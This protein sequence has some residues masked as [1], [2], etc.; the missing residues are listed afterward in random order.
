MKTALASEMREMDRTAIEEYGIPG[1]VLME[2][3]SRTVFE[4]IM[5]IAAEKGFSSAA[6]VCGIG[7]NGGDGFAVAR[8]LDHAG[9]ET[10]V[11]TV[12]DTEKIKGD[13]LINYSAAKKLGIS[14]TGSFN[15]YFLEKCHIIIDAIF[16]TGF[17]VAPKPPFDSVIEKINSLNKYVVSIDVPSG[18]NSDT[19]NVEGACVNADETV[20]FVMP[21]TGMLLYPAAKH[22][23]KITVSDIGMPK[24]ITEGFSS[25][26]L[27]LS[28]NEAKAMLPKRVPDGNKGTFGRVYVAAG[29]ESMMGA[30]YFSSSAA[31]KTGCGLVYCCIPEKCTSLM[32]AL[33][34]EAVEKPLR[35]LSGQFYSESFKRIENEIKL[36]KTVIVGPGIGKGSEIADF[37]HT[38]ILKCTQPL[39]ID[40]DAINA[41][42]HNLTVLKEIKHMSV[43]TPHMGEM[44]RLT[45]I[46]IEEIKKDMIKCAKDF[47][48][49]YNI[50][51]VLKDARTVVASPEGR[52]YINTTGNNSMATGGSGDV[53]T[54]IIGGLLA[55]G[56]SAFEAAVLGTYIHGKCGD[57]AAEEKGHYSVL[58]GDLLAFL[59][60]A[61]KNME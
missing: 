58:A 16:G 12:G 4:R 35:T 1:I 31:Y 44:S 50:V 41:V 32:Q 23:G 55:Q 38:V 15:D 43:I 7:N 19:G 5:K 42:A 28:E 33:L 20:T 29:S 17:K 11:F 54:G 34:P 2:N 56:L 14:I 22:C 37:V 26:A 21:K 25:P 40:A 51:V 18:I 49:E 46:S 61:L 6:V 52:V 9:I 57:M 60:S 13:A 47:A 8:M 27:Y 24:A 48:K 10:K 45:G 59:P 53:L 30:A 3:A 39:V 36:A